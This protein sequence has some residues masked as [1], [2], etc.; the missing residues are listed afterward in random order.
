MYK[1][2]LELWLEIRFQRGR[3]YSSI[4]LT[5]EV[6]TAFYDRNTCELSCSIKLMLHGLVTP[7]KQLRG[8]SEAADGGSL[9]SN[10][11][12]FLQLA[13][14]SISYSI[15]SLNERPSITSLKIR[16]GTEVFALLHVPG[17]AAH[18]STIPVRK[19]TSY[20]LFCQI[21]LGKYSQRVVHFRSTTSI[22]IQFNTIQRR[23]YPI[24]S[25]GTTWWE[26][27]TNTKHL[28][29]ES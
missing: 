14:R 27:C 11:A 28:I 8:P 10:P 24:V 1:R 15:P 26:T 12:F 29:W 9:P 25:T 20:N 23:I 22:C 6:G 7:G 21:Q 18:H 13:S 19:E 16:W 3:R 4:P 2:S 5:A 17:S